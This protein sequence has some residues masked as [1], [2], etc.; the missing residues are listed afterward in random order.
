MTF[1]TILF[2]SVALLVSQTA[3]AAEPP[4][5]AV[6]RQ[7]GMT[8]DDV[9]AIQEIV[10]A[11][12]RA[13]APDGDIHVT[14]VRLGGKIVISLSAAG[15][16]Q[17]IIVS[18][19]EEVPVAAKRLVTATAE[20]VTVEATQDVTNV[21]GGETRPQK[22]KPGEVH[23]WLGANGV[24]FLG[25][26]DAARSGGGASLGVSAGNERWSFLAD[27]RYAGG[28]VGSGAISGG[29]RHHFGTG[30]VSAFV[31]GGIAYLGIESGTSWDSGLALYP[32]VGIDMLRTSKVGG[33]LLFRVEMPTFEVQPPTDRPRV[34]SAYSPYPPPAAPPAAPASS[35]YTPILMLGVAMRF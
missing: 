17:Q 12:A 7:V 1:R 8:D 30:D 10:C 29:I 26:G 21:V 33:A 19:L 18:D 2:S 16:D 20:R 15:L 31:G 23:A 22:R 13:L 27:M 32:E 35:S 24:A 5:C 11:E 4:R 28:A 3:F 9:A 14:V 6:T 34:V 25:G